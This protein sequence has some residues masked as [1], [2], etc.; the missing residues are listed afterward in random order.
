MFKDN[1]FKIDLL[2]KVGRVRIVEISGNLVGALAAAILR[3]AIRE[4]IAKGE[5]YIILNFQGE[6]GVPHINSS[7]VGEL[8]SIFSDLQKLTGRLAL[9]NP[10]KSV[11][12]KLTIC[13]LSKPL[14]CYDTEKQ[15]LDSFG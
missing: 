11:K 12:G 6:D 14:N 13:G 2:R 3:A 1:P 4:L 7:G 10:S 5:R 9:A 8:A 15:A